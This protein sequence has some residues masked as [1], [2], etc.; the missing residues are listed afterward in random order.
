MKIRPLLYLTAFVAAILGATAVYLV[1]SVPNDLRADALLKEAR[2][3][4]TDGDNDKARQSLSKIV[5]EYPRTDAAAA[6]TV[7]LTSLSKKERDDLAREIAK[8]RTE[9]EQQSRMISN[10]QKSVTEV[11][12]APPKIV[13]VQAPAPKPP[14]KKKVTAKKKPTT[15]KRTTRRRR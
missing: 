11:K 1:L 15:K 7:A 10:L 14:A 12:N 2:Q 13:T 6:A 9:N 3:N 4:L 8:L 5:L